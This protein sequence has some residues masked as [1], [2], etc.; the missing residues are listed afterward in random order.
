MVGSH[1]ASRVCTVAQ[2]CA[3]TFAEPC[4]STFAESYARTVAES[5]AFTF[6]DPHATTVAE[7]YASTV[8]EPCAKTFAESHAQT[9][10]ESYAST[11]VEPCATANPSV[12]LCTPSVSTR[13]SASSFCPASVVISPPPWLWCG[14]A[15]PQRSSPL[16]H[17]RGPGLQRIDVRARVPPVRA[18]VPVRAAGREPRSEEHTSEL[19]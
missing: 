13:G 1:H 11:I 14:R 12:M 4:A 15:R 5:Y 10:A 3:S 9:V 7:S 16:R 17:A 6:T 19:Q 2:S 8:A 18:H